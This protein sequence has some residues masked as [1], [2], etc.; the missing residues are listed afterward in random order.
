MS[1]LT[2]NNLNVV[3]I[4]EFNKDVINYVDIIEPGRQK[5]PRSIRCRS[6]MKSRWPC[7]LG[8]DGC[9]RQVTCRPAVNSSLCPSRRSDHCTGR[10]QG[11]VSPL[12]CIP[13]RPAPMPVSASSQACWDSLNDLNNKCCSNKL[14]KLLFTEG[15]SCNTD[16][17]TDMY[18]RKKEKTHTHENT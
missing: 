11:C 10:R 2:S 15:H 13:H 6:S 7:R 16:R 5:T 8:H 14:H 12:G 18:S 4:N 1:T 9:V 3:L 17:M